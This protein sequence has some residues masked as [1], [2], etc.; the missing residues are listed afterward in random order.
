MKG[1]MGSAEHV[2]GYMHCTLKHVVMC[3]DTGDVLVV[4][5]LQEPAAAVDSQGRRHSASLHPSS[6]AA[7]P[8]DDGSQSGKQQAGTTTGSQ[9]PSVARAW[10]E[11]FAWFVYIAWFDAAT[12]CLRHQ[13]HSDLV[14]A[15]CA[16][17]CAL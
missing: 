7:Q 1:V 3:N 11:C 4:V 17:S 16:F 2:V 9:L 8:T 14:V 10:V 12:A 15:A 5:C 6:Q 13:L